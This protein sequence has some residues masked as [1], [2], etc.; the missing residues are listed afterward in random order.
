MGPLDCTYEGWVEFY[1]FGLYARIF[2]DMGFFMY[3]RNCAGCTVTQAFL[4][5]P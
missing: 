2:L 4:T 3:K 5:S 1:Y